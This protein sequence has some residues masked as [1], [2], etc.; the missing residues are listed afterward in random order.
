MKGY[1]GLTLSQKPRVNYKLTL[2]VCHPINYIISTH[3]KVSCDMIK[4]ST[5]DRIMDVVKVY[6]EEIKLNM[7][8]DCRGP[9]GTVYND[10]EISTCE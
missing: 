1:E 5:I 3:Y 8:V 2:L 10:G 4:V 9:L 6:K 7:W